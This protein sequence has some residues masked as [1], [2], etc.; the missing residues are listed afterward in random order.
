MMM[1]MVAPA[2]AAVL[3][4][5]I[6]YSGSN[7]VLSDVE[8]AEAAAAH[9]HPL[10]AAL[11]LG[12]VV[13]IR[14]FGARGSENLRAA[15]IQINRTNRPQRVADEVAAMIAALPQAGVPPQDSTNIIAFLEFGDFACPSGEQVVLITDGLESSA[16]IAAKELMEGKALPAPDAGLLAGC[17][18]TFYGLGVGQPPQVA[19]S[20][21]AQWRAW[22]DGAGATFKPV[23]P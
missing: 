16:Y 21:R 4:L 12:D 22:F 14:T 20:L 5:G 7:P 6:D 13:R 11:E 18:V 23:V 2:G 10:I 17:Q 1:T 9:V 3:T 15:T 8:F 19:K